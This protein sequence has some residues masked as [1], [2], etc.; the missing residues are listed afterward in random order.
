MSIGS[1][2][3]G[4][5]MVVEANVDADVTTVEEAAAILVDLVEACVLLTPQSGAY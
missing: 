3:L 5:V 2:L 4:P 1:W